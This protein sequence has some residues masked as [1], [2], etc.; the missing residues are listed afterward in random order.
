MENYFYIRSSC[1]C[2]EQ[3]LSLQMLQDVYIDKNVRAYT[4]RSLMDWAFILDNGV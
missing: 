1:C 3:A 2:L 4:V